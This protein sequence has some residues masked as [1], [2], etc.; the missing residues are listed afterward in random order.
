MF[1]LDRFLADCVSVLGERSPQAAV[2][3]LVHRAVSEPA[4]VEAALGTPKH[5]ELTILLGTPELTVLKVVWAPGMDFRP[6]DH[7]MWAVIG[8]YGGREDNTFYRRSPGR[9]T[10]A[11]GTSLMTRDTTVLGNDVIHSVA[12][13]LGSYCAAIHV[14]GGEF[15]AAR[16]S[17]WDPETG[18]E[19]PFDVEAGKR[20][21]LEWPTIS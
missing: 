19:R 9:L 21:F 18:A 11:G 6:H 14:Y 10:A 8:I 17:E 12:N 3:Q 7:R 2:Q 4:E 1:D 15:F 5:A 13:P 16:R 20:Y